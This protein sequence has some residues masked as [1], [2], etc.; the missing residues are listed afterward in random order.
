MA[1]HASAPGVADGLRSLA[2]RYLDEAGRVGMIRHPMGAA[3]WLIGFIGQD[4]ILK[5]A[6]ALL[7]SLCH[8]PPL[9]LHSAGP[10]AVVC[11]G[12]PA[13]DR[14][15]IGTLNCQRENVESYRGCKRNRGEG[16]PHHFPPPCRYLATNSPPVSSVPHWKEKSCSSF[17]HHGSVPGNCG[18][19]RRVSRKRSKEACRDRPAKTRR[20][21][22]AH[23]H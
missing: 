14:L 4:C 22:R 9:G 17:D 8:K 7:Q 23:H 5:M 12:R 13:K 6:D 10:S 21:G 16:K 3:R 18:R 1:Q 11:E 19:S 20:W 15:T 2:A